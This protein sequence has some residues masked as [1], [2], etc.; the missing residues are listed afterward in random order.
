VTDIATSCDGASGE[1]LVARVAA[2]RDAIA[3]AAP[4]Q[5][6]E[7]EAYEHARARMREL[8]LVVRRLVD[9]ASEQ[10]AECAICCNELTRHT[11]RIAACCQG[12]FCESCIQRIRACALCRAPMARSLVMDATPA[13]PPE[14]K[15]LPRPTRPPTTVRP[16]ELSRAIDAINEKVLVESVTLRDSII[17]LIRAHVTLETQRP[18]RI[19][20]YFN[21]QDVNRQSQTSVARAIEESAGAD[22]R[23]LNGY[24]AVA[25]DVAVY[26]GSGARPVVL[27]CGC[28]RRSQLV[29]GLDFKNTT[30]MIFHGQIDASH[31]EQMR[32]R[33]MRVH[34]RKTPFAAQLVVTQCIGK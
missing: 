3:S 24:G 15:R 9:N 12:L 7:A 34:A 8:A 5:P 31:A 14:A 10:G 21:E 19:L 28:S 23:N 27:L 4:A 25:S 13:P 26:K 1:A 18:V 6:S 17:E 11:M 29:S 30:L 22:V 32:G 2:V 20:F 33:M 16:S